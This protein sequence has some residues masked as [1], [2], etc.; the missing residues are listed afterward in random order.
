MFKDIFQPDILLNHIQDL[1]LKML[2][3]Y[4][5]KTLILDVDNTLIQ[6]RDKTLSEDILNAIKKFKSIELKIVLIS[7]NSSL[8]RVQLSQF[9]GLDSLF[10]ALKPFTRRFKHFKNKLSLEYPMMLV[11]DQVFTDIIFAKR[12][13][14]ISVLVN[15]LSKNEYLS[16]RILRYIESRLVK[17]V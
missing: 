10:F 16:T 12:I 11:G 1:D 14:A 4:K 15:P 9:L 17:R 7:N 8:E 5:I 13:R 2:K 6:K 3:D